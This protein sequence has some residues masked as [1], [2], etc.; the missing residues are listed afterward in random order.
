LA[1]RWSG[2]CNQLSAM[3]KPFRFSLQKVLEYRGQLEDQ[4]KIALAKAQQ[5]HLD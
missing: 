4:A 2:S 5:A 1:G 3:P